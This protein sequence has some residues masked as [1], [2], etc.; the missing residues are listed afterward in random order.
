MSRIWVAL[1]LV[2]GLLYAGASLADGTAPDQAV[3]KSVV[4]GQMDAF[5]RDDAGAAYQFA[6]PK[7]QLLFPTAEAFIGM[8]REVYKPVYRPAA[9]AFGPVAMG[10][11]GPTEKVFITAADGTN[12]IALYSF[13]QQAGGSWKISGCLLLRDTAATI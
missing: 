12:W 9:L 4:E 7:I 8:V 3:L 11:G 2:V 5:K 13:E 1:S 6:A 10:P